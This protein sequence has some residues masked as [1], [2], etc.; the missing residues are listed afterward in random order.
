[1][2][3]SVKAM[4]PFA[5]FKSGIV[6]HAEAMI[7]IASHSLQYGTMCFGGM[8]GYVVGKEARILRL[9]DHHERLM[10]AAKI[11]GF[12]YYMP[13]EKFHAVISEVIKANA[14]QTD[15]YLRP[16]IFS[17]DEVI[18][19]CM[20][21]RSYHLAVYLLPLNQYFKKAGGLRL[22]VSSRK[23]FSDV[24]M[25]T[26]AKASGC[27]LNS[28]LATS[29][30]RRCGYD[31]ALMMDDVGS[32]VEASVANLFIVYRGEVLTPAIGSGP[33]EGI[34]MRTVIDLLKDD[35]IQVN[36][37][38]IDRSMLYTSDEV[39]LTGSAAQVS[40]V[41]S[42]DSRVIG[43]NPTPTMGPI[44]ARTQAL[45]TQLIS[46][47]HRLSREYMSVFEC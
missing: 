24:S 9:R 18:G 25:S 29:E 28:A 34:T 12:K 38:V 15:F 46:M 32:I 4:M 20:D 22:M 11:L 21:E 26:K 39:F 6:P 10:N 45:F 47:D 14:P 19:P 37:A 35:N 13:Y 5:Y 44:C 40:Y 2:S 3:T 17:D 1:M 27:Y 30:A 16:F 41:E 42:I 31:E 43:P 7:S 36:I 23:K 33:L 8:R